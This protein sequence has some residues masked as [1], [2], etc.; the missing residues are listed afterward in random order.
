MAIS[1]AVRL[2][3]SRITSAHS[4]FQ[5][6][7]AAGLPVP[8]ATPALERS[9]THA[10]VSFRRACGRWAGCRAA[11]SSSGRHPR[12]AT[13]VCTSTPLPLG[14]DRCWL[15]T[16]ISRHTALPASACLRPRQTAC[17]RFAGT[18][19]IPGCPPATCLRASVHRAA[20]P[21]PLPDH[22]GPWSPDLSSGRRCTGAGLPPRL[23]SL[24]EV[25]DLSDRRWG[26][27]L[28]HTVRRAP[29]PVWL[30]S[31]SSSAPR[32]YTSTSVF[33]PP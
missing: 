29:P 4:S 17:R 10:R 12:L 19:G 22:G 6:L 9:R 18:G 32:E 1:I 7:L 31:N 20:R 16:P 8:C 24:S 27:T 13:V 3:T 11:T 33:P 26:D 28:P 23:P 2:S 5:F 14:R 21:P 30:P 15:S 25:T